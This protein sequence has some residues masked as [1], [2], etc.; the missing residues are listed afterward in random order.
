MSEDIES[1]RHQIAELEAALQQQLPPI[2]ETL[3]RQQL[4]AL[5]S[6][7]SIN[8]SNF[9]SANVAAQNIIGHDLNQQTGTA[10]NSGQN[11]GAVIGLN[12][13][14]IVFGR[15]PSEDEQRR[16]SRYLTALANKWSKLDLRGKD[17][18][19][20]ED[21]QLSLAQ[22]YTMVAL[23]NSYVFLRQATQIE[24]TT[25]LYT[26]TGLSKKEDPSH[27][28]PDKAISK[29]DSNPDQKEEFLA[30][31]SLLATEAVSENQYLILLGDP[32][33]GKS[34]FIRYL[35]M[36]LAQH[37]S[38]HSSLSARLPGWN[39]ERQLLP[40][41]ISLRELA[42]ILARESR[43]PKTVYKMLHQTMESYNIADVDDLLSETLHS[44]VALLLFDGLDEVPL[45]GVSGKV[46][47]RFTTLRAVRDFAQQHNGARIVVTCRTRAYEGKL[48][49]CVKWPV[50]TLAPWTLGQIRH[51]V[52]V[53]YNELAAT[54]GMEAAQAE[55]AARDLLAAIVERP[56]LAEMARTP[57]LLTMMALVLYN[58][59]TLPRDRPQLYERV[60]SMLLG[61][62]DSLRGGDNLATAIG[63]PNWDSGR[64]RGVL[65]ELSYIAHR[66]ATSADGRGRISRQTLRDKLIEFFKNAGLPGYADAA[67][68]CLEYFQQRSGLLLP[69]DEHNSFTF[70]HLTLQ[71]HCAGCYLVSQ[72]S[73]IDEVL[74]HRTD[75]RFREPIF[76]GL[77]KLQEGPQGW[78][79]IETILN[80]LLN[81]SESNGIP[82]SIQQWMHDIILAAE[83]GIDRDWNR[84]SESGM[85]TFDITNNL[86][87]GLEYILAD[88]FDDLVSNSSNHD[89]LRKCIDLI[90]FFGRKKYEITAKDW[91]DFTKEIIISIPKDNTNEDDTEDDDED[92]E[93]DE[94][95]IT[96]YEEDNNYNERE[97]VYITIPQ[98]R[99][100]TRNISCWNYSHFLRKSSNQVY[101]HN[102]DSLNQLNLPI[103]TLRYEEMVSYC[104]WLTITGIT[105]GWLTPDMIVRLP[106]EAEI[107]AYTLF[108]QNTFGSVYTNEMTISESI[109]TY[110][111]GYYSY[112]KERII[113]KKFFATGIDGPVD[114]PPSLSLRDEE[115]L[116]YDE[117]FDYGVAFRV[118][119]SYKKP[120]MIGQ[121]T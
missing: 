76:L 101:Q 95:S 57:L 85:N 55:R 116:Y 53:W 45:E 63:H 72:R 33:G 13:G 66:D 14:K 48:R 18:R 1:L 17:D 30:L 68:R 36:T 16:L 82:K 51:F 2:V 115:E 106:T 28:L 41:I 81:R 35:A 3:T 46:A 99:I 109:E 25:Y 74:N 121:D 111:D 32:G 24:R 15:D 60:L 114:L 31:R 23:Q 26:S 103:T 58:D 21:D 70:A 34:T 94:Y 78:V 86:C 59:G 107:H 47:D 73:V 22:V 69:D 6:Q 100:L 119:I 37:N 90:A 12:L 52:P 64:I 105:D 54:T 91:L 71:E 80:R 39:D 120:K 79:F 117:R 42:G 4:A 44:G 113:Y 88:Y 50:E 8:E 102:V 98:F 11:N 29:I 110:S 19:S 40:I 9:T 108:N 43:S 5:Q 20:G 83:V 27:V 75:D 97:L 7:L 10:Q 92:Y 104:E 112:S 38:I 62:W 77:G 87:S 96:Y 56:K 84:L 118:V 65:D 61:R 67:E 49:E 93:D 89:Y